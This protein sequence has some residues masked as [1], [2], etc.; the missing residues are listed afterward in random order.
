M[1][2]RSLPRIAVTMGDPAGIGPELCLRV[3]NDERLRSVCRPLVIG[4]LP[5]LQRVGRQ[6]QLAVPTDAVFDAVALDARAVRPGE[7]DALGGQA[8]AACIEKAIAMALEGRAE[9]VTTAPVH[10]E[11]LRR[12]GVPYP[13]HTELF[14]AR[15][16]TRR[17]CMM[18]TSRAL[19]A[20]FVTTHL[21][22]K[23]V[24]REITRDRILEVVE[25]TAQAMMRIRG[26]SPRLTVC[27][28]NPHAGEGGLF[29][30]EETRVIAPAVAEARQRGFRVEGPLPPD[31]AFLAAKRAET[32]AY[33]CMYHDQGHI[34]LKML[35][36]DSAVN[37]TLGLPIV[38]TSPDHGTAFDIAWQGR[39][40]PGSL[41]AAVRLAALLVANPVKIYAQKH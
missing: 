30:R 17:F 15:T 8:A 1:S 21:A 35:A 3:L 40:D 25:L 19:T 31:T 2:S 13:G 26:S 29:G 20:S 6:C 23:A 7:I 32:D 14:A 37:V 10:K 39:A 12:A 18:Q 28:L 33:I 11:A 38:R 5:L 24:A 9:A 34:P 22:L 27:G 16:G 4:S 41:T 36:F